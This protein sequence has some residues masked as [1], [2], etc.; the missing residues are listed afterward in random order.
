MWG[1]RAMPNSTVNERDIKNF[2]D[3]SSKWWDPDGPFRML[4]SMNPLRISFILDN[5]KN[6]KKLNILDVGTGGGLLSIPLANLG[7]KVTAIDACKQSIEVAQ[8]RAKRFNITNISFV[9]A[10]VEEFVKHKKVKGSFD[11]I[12]ASE[13]VEHVDSFGFFMQSL[14][15]LLKEEGQVFIS[16]IN[17]TLKSLLFAKIAAEYIMRLV[18]CETH[19][20]NNFKKPSEI[21]SAIESNHKF[22][23][24]DLTGL[25]FNPLNKSWSKTKSIAI[26]YMMMLK[27]KARK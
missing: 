6:I 25:A 12:C 26:N 21:I 16:T 7:A 2:A 4:H 1:G 13:V 17:R 3:L 23:V 10:P 9:C 24:M 8:D 19:D 22:E 15:L 5:V 18:P 27:R 14:N 20:W 11:M